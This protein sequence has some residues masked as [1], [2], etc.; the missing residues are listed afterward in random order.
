VERGGLGFWGTT[1]AGVVSAIVAGVLT[2][3]FG[4]W[5]PVWR[6]L[7]GAFETLWG[8]IS[9]SVSVPLSILAAVAFLFFWLARRAFASTFSAEPP[10][11]V[12]RV[13]P[14][15]D[16]SL[17]PIEL[18]ILELLTRADG[19]WL[20]IERIASELHVSRL[21]TERALEQLFARGYL[22]DNH[23]VLHGTMFRLSPTGRDYALDRGL[24]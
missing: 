6:W 14:Q 16:P 15:P 21:V 22:L 20:E 18:A 12:S 13:S 24:G 7:S 3:L 1:L 8:W 2:W 9:Y 5:P 4:F 19:Q 10:T 23:N 17:A 11:A